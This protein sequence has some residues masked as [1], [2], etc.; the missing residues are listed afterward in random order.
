[1]YGE[2]RLRGVSEAPRDLHRLHEPRGQAPAPEREG[3]AQGADAEQPQPEAM[4]LEGSDRGRGKGGEAD[5]EAQ[6]IREAAGKEIAAPPAVGQAGWISVESGHHRLHEGQGMDRVREHD[7]GR[8]AR[9]ARAVAGDAGDDSGDGAAQGGAQRQRRRHPREAGRAAGQGEDEA[10][11]DRLR[12]HLGRGRAHEDADG[13]GREGDLP[14]SAAGGEVEPQQDRGRPGQGL[15]VDV[16]VQRREREAAEG[17]DERGGGGARKGEAERLPRE[18][19][20]PD[21]GQRY[22]QRE[23]EGEAGLVGPQQR[24]QLERIGQ[25]RQRERL[26]LVGV[27]VPEAHLAAGEAL[28]DE[29]PQGEEVQ[30][31]VAEVERMARERPAQEGQ[32]RHRRHGRVGPGARGAAHGIVRSGR[33][34][35]PATTVRGG[36][37][38]TTTLPAATKDSGPMV[39]PGSIGDRGAEEAAAADGHRRGHGRESAPA[40]G[41]RDSRRW[42][43]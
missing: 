19:H 37:S 32:R 16:Q 21:R 27:R 36:T 11:E 5:V 39:R 26:A 22:V 20:H 17:V 30:R 25:G 3:E 4:R 9:G 10:D 40:A 18:G 7:L 38:S 24:E 15:R 14:R 6:E 1:M 13:D 41:G 34:G 42:C 8:E 33:A 28:E 2:E 12:D 23:E 35:T 29:P 31:E 43:G